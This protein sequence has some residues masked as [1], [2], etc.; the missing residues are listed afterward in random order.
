MC[1]VHWQT[2]CFSRRR[3]SRLQHHFLPPPHANPGSLQPRLLP[4]DRMSLG[5]RPSCSCPQAACSLG[6]GRRQVGP[7]QACLPSRGCPRS[8]SKPT[9]FRASR[10]KDLPLSS[11][12]V[13]HPPQLCPATRPS[14]LLSPLDTLSPQGLCLERSRPAATGPLPSPPSSFGPSGPF[15]ARPALSQ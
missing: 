3:T 12:P 4:G 1:P 14:L 5:P 6:S 15:S 13:C 9:S 2:L 7:S 8:E 10:S 11:Q